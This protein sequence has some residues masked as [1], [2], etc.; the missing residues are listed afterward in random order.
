MNPKLHWESNL[1]ESRANLPAM[2][3]ISQ[4]SKMLQVREWKSNRLIREAALGN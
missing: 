2:P 4:S 3:M 1:R